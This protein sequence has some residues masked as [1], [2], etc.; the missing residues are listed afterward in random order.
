MSHESGKLGHHCPTSMALLLCSHFQTSSVCQSNGRAP[1]F[2]ALPSFPNQRA[3]VSASTS[4]TLPY[5]GQ[6]TR[7]AAQAQLSAWES[8]LLL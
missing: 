2:K 1:T 6:S 7:L 3:L 5:S 8:C 4:L